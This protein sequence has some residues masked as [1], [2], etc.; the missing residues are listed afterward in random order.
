M[1]FVVLGNV[2]EVTRGNSGIFLDGG[3]APYNKQPT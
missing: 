2:S 1:Q 3:D